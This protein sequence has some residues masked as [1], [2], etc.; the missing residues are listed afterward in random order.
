MLKYFRNKTF[1][2]GII[3]F[4]LIFLF[5]TAGLIHTPFDPNEICPEEKLLAPS[6]THLLGT[7]NLGR[8]VLSR[9]MAGTRISILLGFCVMIFGLV[10]GLILGSISGWFG[11]TTDIIVMKLI[12]TQMAF[13]GILLALMLVAVFQP[14]IK[15]TFLSLCIMSIP[16]FTRITRACYIKYRNSLF[17]QA[18]KAR[19]AGNF[20]IMYIHILPN[21]I[22]ELL[23]TATTSF[24]MAI[25]S[26]SGLSY[27]GL[28]VQ[29]PHPS[30]GRMLND[31]QHYIFTNP[32]GVLIPLS[33]LCLLVSGINLIG[34]GISQVNRK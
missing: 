14:D 23:V 28:G 24:S 5:M 26:E 12:N 1:L 16:H 34:D 33:F 29:P 19:G 11:G 17:V 7:D 22:S 21:I 31:A 30:F 15:I 20:R 6:K 25:L 8:D 27:L 9:I 32:A 10:S 13:P 18:A 4:G 3:L 2:T